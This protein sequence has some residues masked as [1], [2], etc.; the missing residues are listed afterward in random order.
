M[1]IEYKN[2]EFSGVLIIQDSTF[3]INYIESGTKLQIVIDLAT[4]YEKKELI[5]P[6][7]NLLK[8][9][10]HSG[11][12]SCR[13]SYSSTLNNIIGKLCNVIIKIS[14]YI[15]LTIDFRIISLNL[16]EGNNS[17]FPYMCIHN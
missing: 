3:I 6:I 8:T 15:T 2:I 9:S 13:I 4:E 11:G 10:M 5:D 1:N 7:I 12:N 14:D 17:C 16:Y